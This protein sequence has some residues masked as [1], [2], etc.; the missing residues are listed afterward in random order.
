M[1]K[2]ESGQFIEVNKIQAF[3]TA[4]QPEIQLTI[5]GNWELMNLQ[6]NVFELQNQMRD[7]IDK[8]EEEDRLIA[9][10]PALKD[11]HDQY[12]VVFTL[13]KKADDA[14]NEKCSGGG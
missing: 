5:Q 14:L 2:I 13:V 1:L 9:E 7:M 3:D 6:N 8:Q 10:N 4:G 11:L 12:K